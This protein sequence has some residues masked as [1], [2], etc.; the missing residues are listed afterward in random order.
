MGEIR[1]VYVWENLWGNKVSLRMGKYMRQIRS[2]YV[3]ENK[4]YMG[5]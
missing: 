5:E 4:V 1:S 2:V 3:W